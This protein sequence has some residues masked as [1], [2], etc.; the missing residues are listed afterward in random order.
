[1]FGENYIVTAQSL[2]LQSYGEN[3]WVSYD[4]EE[5]IQA[6]VNLANELGYVFTYLPFTPRE[7]PARTSSDT[8]S[9]K[10]SLYSTI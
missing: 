5:T 7:F 3:N 8:S 1:M 6:K 4:N 2:T 10:V 9:D